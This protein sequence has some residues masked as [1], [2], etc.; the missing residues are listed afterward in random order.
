M[1]PDAIAIIGM[2]CRLPQSP[3]PES[4][5]QLLRTGRDA[6]TEPPADRRHAS[7]RPGGYLDRVDQ[8]DAGFF[9]IAPRE[10]A[11]M[12]PRQRLMLELSW[13]ALEDAA[14]DPARL[15]G[16]GTAVVVGAIG[17]DYATLAQGHGATID[18][19]TMTGLH[20]GLIANRVSH[21]LDLCGP[22]MTVDTGQ[23]SSLVAVHLACQSLRTGESALA[24]AGGVSLN[25]APESTLSAER[26][27]A[28]SPDH[29]C[30]T[31]D[32]RANGY[33]RGEGG[34]LVVL[35]PL[36]RA[37]ADADPVYCVIRGSAV[38]ND[39]HTD[40]LTVPSVEAQR[41]VIRLACER[42]GV[43]PG[44]VQHV[45]LHGTG[46]RIGDP[47]E[48]S[49]LGAV[50][51]ADRTDGTA[52]RVG[53]VKTNIGHL[54]GAAGI[55][56]LLKAALSISNREI[57]PS[58]HFANAHPRIPLD[59][60]GLRVQT[61]L[62]PWPRPDAPLLSG[63]SSFGMGG[64]N[65]HVL[66]SDG[67]R[68][69]REPVTA[70]FAGAAFS[71]GSDRAP[72]PWVVS[73]KTAPGLRAQA[74]RLHT[75]LSGRPDLDVVDVGHTLAAGRSPLPHRAVVLAPTR[76]ELL[77]GLAA[78]A[79]QEP[80]EHVFRGT[81]GEPG[82]TLFV[83]TGH[84]PFDTEAALRLLAS[85]VSAARR[86]GECDAALLPLTGWSVLD[87]LRAAP[88]AP[89]LDRTEVVAPVRFATM[90][91]LAELWREYGVE[92]AGVAGHGDGEVAAACVAGGLSLADAA[93]VIVALS[94][95]DAPTDIAPRTCA[96]PFHAAA[97]GAVLDTA[98]LDARY[99]RSVRSSATGRSSDAALLG[100]G[101]RRIVEVDPGR[102]PEEALARGYV[103]GA[104]VRW[105]HAFAGRTPRRAHLPTYP[106]ERRRHWLA[107]KAVAEAP[108]TA[109]AAPRRSLLDLVRTEAAAV[110]GH[111]N[112]D[113]VAADLPLHDAGLHSMGAVEL[114]ERLSA[115]TGVDLPDTL[116]F[117]HPTPAALARHLRE[118]TTAGQP[119]PA[120]PAGPDL[121]RL[122]AQLLAVGDD[123]RASVAARLR[124][125]AARLDVR[126]EGRPAGHDFAAAT[127]EQLFAALDY[128]PSTRWVNDGR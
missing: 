121:G 32:A 111:A 75:H 48:A 18:A 2:A 13:E 65:C 9:A 71:P 10:A 78:V 51:G 84:T 125:L 5:W 36:D 70:V 101:Y 61:T 117:D 4:F 90:L 64:T 99:W 41:E 8:F 102:P 128:T 22:S 45:E 126:N 79:R 17:D 73:A 39:G 72:I 34:G 119:A 107:E 85:S 19:H 23:S 7:A 25:L 56:G 1:H 55:A 29:R 100:M 35:K 54:E 30:R 89:P 43:D 58:L 44:Q 37:I 27:G 123:Q 96:I 28:L 94:T 76:R 77:A 16:S 114:C 120:G 42:A 3:D 31:F 66:L 74:A 118:R 108:S 105:E 106:F 93:R 15:A 59:E 104:P 87:V 88:T 69:P 6:I 24:I 50:Y 91:A 57:P 124:D 83:F 113:D 86:L 110:L 26:F 80:A 115:V 52:L 38:N 82:G 47:V 67:P 97:S 14:I 122:E 116:L 20:R 103:S 92:P 49:A 21:A 127:D 95:G 53:S 63:V 11:A 33:V 98:A 109:T 68:P 112:P 40:G 46:T 81:A 12:D 60:W 62:G